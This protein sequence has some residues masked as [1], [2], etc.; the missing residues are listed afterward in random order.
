MRTAPCRLVLAG[1]LLV[2]SGMLG[3]SQSSPTNRDIP[4]PTPAAPTPPADQHE[5]LRKELEANYARI[6]DGFKKNDPSIWEGYLVPDFQLK[7][8]NGQ[9]QNRQW[10]S[11]Y[12]R[13]NAKTF[14]VVK[15]TMRIK[16]LA[17]EGDEA[18][19]IVEQESLRTFKDEQEKE[20]QLEVGAIQRETWTKTP[21]G[22]RLKLVQEKEVLYLRQ[23][24]KPMRQ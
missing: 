23:D 16:E 11:D 2:V 6:V 13:N 4:Q 21:D 22:M 14:K 1:T 18:V 3:C 9:V 20:H 17:V 12:V 24:G 5:N 8:F 19:A 10:V 7:L 15:L